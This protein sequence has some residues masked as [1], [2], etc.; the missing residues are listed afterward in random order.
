MILLAGMLGTRASTMLDLLF[1]AMFV[2][3]PTMLLGIHQAK[4]QRYAR[5]K[6][7]M[8]ALVAVLLV[9]V[10]AFEINIQTYGWEQHA[11]GSPYYS[12]PV[13]TSGVGIS[14]II[15]LVFAVSTAVL[16]VVVVTRA[17]R[18]FPKP[19]TPSEHS[20]SHVRW[21]KLAALDMILTAVTGCIFYVIAFVLG[22]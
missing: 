14:L 9:T 21:A 11:V 3:V 8:L 12:E 13:A 19:P 16:W 7:V 18:R 22:E 1:L 4:K 6:S 17:L 5:H 10:A 20:R 15:H 2:V